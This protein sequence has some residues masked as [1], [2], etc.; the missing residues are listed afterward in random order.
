[1]EIRAERWDK[2]GEKEKGR[3]RSKISTTKGAAI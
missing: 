3:I 1:M 2:S